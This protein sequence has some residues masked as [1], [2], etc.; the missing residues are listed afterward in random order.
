M[1]PGI[2]D[3]TLHVGS[4]TVVTDAEI[5]RSSRD[6]R[7]ATGQLVRLPASIAGISKFGWTTLQTFEATE[8]NARTK[9]AQQRFDV[10]PIENN[11]QVEEYFRTVQWNDYSRVVR[12]RM[13]EEDVIPYDTDIRDVI[14]LLS[15]RSRAF[16]FLSDD[17]DIVGLISVVNLNRLPVKVWFF[18]LLSEVEVR[19]GKFI[20]SRVSD[21][22]ELYKLTLG[23]TTDP[24]YDKVKRRYQTDQ[25]KGLELP[26]V[27]YLYFSDLV[28]L[29][30]TKE[31]HSS[32]GY[33]PNRFKRS[34]GSLANL[35]DEIAHPAR[36][37][38]RHTT[39]VAQL[40]RRIERIDDALERLRQSLTYA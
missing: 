3:K 23:A 17:R 12:D 36:S 35:R 39:A 18:S 13:S 34:L 28:R 32:L 14:R 10:L 16:F 5:M 29:V 11:G 26:V 20:S 24:K 1:L 22:D 2:T 7:F 37:L 15:E 6:P 21:D 9:M 4:G 8:E 30:I 33:T 25:A 31:L 38:V 19:L 40:W 27:E